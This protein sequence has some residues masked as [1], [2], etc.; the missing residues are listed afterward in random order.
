MDAR[1]TTIKYGLCVLLAMLY[2]TLYIFDI[3]FDYVCLLY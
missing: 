2:N 1:G 3:V